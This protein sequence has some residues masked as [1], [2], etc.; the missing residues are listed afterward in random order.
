MKELLETI[1]FDMAKIKNK[2]LWK[3]MSISEL[4][5]WKQ[6][7]VMK[8]QIFQGKHW[9]NCVIGNYHVRLL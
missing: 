3:G 4:N 1:T 2:V 5:Y 8:I 9:K 6:Y 7:F